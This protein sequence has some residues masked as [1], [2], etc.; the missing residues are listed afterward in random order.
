MDPVTP[1]AE[2]APSETTQAAT[3]TAP[4]AAMPALKPGEAT[5]LAAQVEKDAD[6]WFAKR[7]ENLQLKPEEPAKTDETGEALES[8]PEGENEPTASDGTAPADTALTEADRHLLSRWKL[9]QEQTDQLLANPALART[10]LDNAHRV[11]QYAD[12]VAQ[13]R[14]PAQAAADEA[15]PAADPTPAF[16]SPDE[17]WKPLSDTWLD[18]ET[19]QALRTGVERTVAP[20]LQTMQNQ[21][22]Y[23][24]MQQVES[25]IKGLELP[26]GVDVKDPQIR[27][28]I[29]TKAYELLQTQ[30]Y[31]LFGNNW[32]HAIPAAAAALYTNQIVQAD[33]ARKQQAARQSRRGTASPPA[34]MATSQPAPTADEVEDATLDKILKKHGIS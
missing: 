15:A 22:R 9:T 14:T 13:G 24:E 27:K 18:A 21:Q 16:N 12:R 20:I 28:A 19:T 1:A 34:R 3:P 4:A 30:G 23:I 2:A 33:K 31:D 25:A 6:A 8:E 7:D 11:Q 5:S 32:T 29:E 10:I 17:V 26:A